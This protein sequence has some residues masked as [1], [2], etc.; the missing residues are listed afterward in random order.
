VRKRGL[1][2][3]LLALCALGI[4]AVAISVVRPSQPIS[5]RVI[6]LDGRP[7]AN[8]TAEMVGHTATSG[9][10]GRFE[11]RG[12]P[13]EGWVRV[14]AAG[15]M[16]R[17]RPAM[18]GHETVF[19]LTPD[20]G[21]TI[22]LIFG[23]DVMFGRRFFDPNED[24]DPSDGQLRPDSSATDEARLLDGVHEPLA[25]ADLA[26]VN[27]E[28]PLIADPYIN[29][30]AARPAGVHQAKEFVFA[31]NPASAA[32]LAQVGIDVVGIGNNHLYDA[33][34][35]GVT[36]T[37]S[38]L[39]SAGFTAGAHRTGGGIDQADAWVPAIATAHGTSVAFL[40]CTT[41]TGVETPPLYTATDE[42]GG[43]AE[44]TEE[45]IRNAVS[46]ARLR[47]STVVVMIHGGFE[48]DR[49]P[50]EHI[51]AL[52]AAA[53]DAGATLV[54]NS[55][56]HVIGGF[57]SNQMGLTAWTMGNLLFDQTV[58]P[59]FESYLLTVHVRDGRPIRAMVDP[60]VMDD[61]RPEPILGD[62]ADHVARDAAGWDAGPFVIEDGSV[63]IGDPALVSA[64]QV[65]VTEP[66][67]GT[68]FHL[69]G[70]TQ[71]MSASAPPDLEVGRDLLWTGDFE[72]EEADRQSA[73]GLLWGGESRGR[74]FI[75][76]AAATGAYGAR[77]ERAGGN[78][79]DVVLAPIHRV[80]VDAGTKLTI[81]AKLRGSAGTPQ[82]QLQLSW[83]ND[84]K[85][86]SEAQTI[87]DLPVKGEWQTIAV[88]VVVPDHAVAVLP[89]IRLAPP[90]PGRVSLDVDDVRLIAWRPGPEA[91]LANDYVRIGKDGTAFGVAVNSLAGEAVDP[92]LPVL[93][94]VDATIAGEPVSPLP[95][96]PDETTDEGD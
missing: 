69:A 57:E 5:G 1:L 48:Y 22:S 93:V 95:P 64:N 53:H 86:A 71:V 18:A 91:T 79:E 61:F 75:P 88:D 40:A 42:K 7:I 3:A 36:S 38:A 80:P 92:A 31:S 82:A 19:R 83:Y 78:T 49:S 23:G 47:A 41:V 29:P 76:D 30:V 59:T 68:I 21:K 70:D 15:F 39:D 27:L 20:D 17:L 55:H 6:G 56:P 28:T 81:L 89:L 72:D 50:S 66:T 37:L 10:D 43:A 84:L 45:A 24:G 11:I 8:A 58:W 60:L 85:G 96:G 44:C 13:A 87:V 14:D 12:A 2:V 63:E 73:G 25:A 67:A 65:S 32:A 52:T 77:L 16:P 4:A 34:D 33:L 62:R 74:T 26:I 94:P 54:I 46:A 51:S 90:G 9:A 35:A